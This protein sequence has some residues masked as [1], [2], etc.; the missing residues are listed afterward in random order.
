MGMLMQVGVGA[1][2]DPPV[3]AAKLFPCLSLPYKRWLS[4]KPT[5]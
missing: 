2:V 1:V 3:Y 4:P 5:Q